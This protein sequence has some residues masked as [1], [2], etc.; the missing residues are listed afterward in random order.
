[1]KDPQNSPKKGLVAILD[2]APNVPNMLQLPDVK[3]KFINNYLQT[4]GRQDGQERFNEELNYFLE[5]VRS[6]DKISQCD[7]LS[8]FLAFV[9]ISTYGLSFRDDQ[10]YAIPY[11]D[12]VQKTNILKCRPGANGKMEMIRRMKTV[13]FVHEPFIV[14]AKDEFKYDYIKSKVKEYQPVDR[15]DYKWE[16]IV[17]AVMIIEFV[18]G[19][20]IHVYMNKKDL[21]GAKA[22]AQTD[23]VYKSHPGEMA[24]KCVKNRA[25]KLYFRREELP[26]KLDPNFDTSPDM[27]IQDSGYVDMD[28]KQEVRPEPEQTPEPPKE[29]PESTIEDAEVIEEDDKD[30]MF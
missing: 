21:N 19:R 17:G 12:K 11:W 16:D 9:S 15:H 26:F 22:M 10:V 25:Y 29:E 6:N 27:D 2:A 28:T 23:K 8:V 30:E 1:M 24:K 5:I 18:D 3:K 7:R 20:E 13:K 14:L 4:T